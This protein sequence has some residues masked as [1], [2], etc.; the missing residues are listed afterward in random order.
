MA[1]V[2]RVVAP[3][4]TRSPPWLSRLAAPAGPVAL[5]ASGSRKAIFSLLAQPFILKPPTGN[6]SI[7]S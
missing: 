4:T 1:Q 2:P 7:L 3:G 5:A 6:I